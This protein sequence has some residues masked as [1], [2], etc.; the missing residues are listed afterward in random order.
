MV[1]SEMSA[2]KR[3]TTTSKTKSKFSKRG[4]RVDTHLFGDS[5][6]ASTFLSVGYRPFPNGKIPPINHS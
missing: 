4:E 6:V 2:S 1:R 3:S 5:K